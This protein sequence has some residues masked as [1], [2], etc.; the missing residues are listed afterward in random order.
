[1][2]P[3]TAFTVYNPRARR[4]TEKKKKIMNVFSWLPICRSLVHSY[5]KRRATSFVSGYFPAYKIYLQTSQK[6][7][8]PP[9]TSL[10]HFTLS[11]LFMLQSVGVDFPTA[12]HSFR[13]MN[14]S[15]TISIHG[16]CSKLDTWK[17]KSPCIYFLYF[18][19]W[20]LVTIE[21]MLQCPAVVKTADRHYSD[22]CATL[23]S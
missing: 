23:K 7:G 2:S 16:Y 6:T 19:N 10:K 9:L 14:T 1:M 18:K 5:Y 4:E 22:C 13:W 20:S 8:F 21:V 3:Y 15:T 11:Q 12:F 17:G